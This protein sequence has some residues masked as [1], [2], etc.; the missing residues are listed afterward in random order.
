[1]ATKSGYVYIY[2]SNESPVD[3][4]FDNLQVIHTRGAILEETHYYP[5]GLTMAGISSK[6]LAFGEPEN[7]YKYNGIEHNNDFDLNMYD[8]FYRNLDP[9]IGRFWQVDPETE[10][11][12]EYS[13][14]ASMYNNP[15]SNAD[16]LGDF[17][18]R[19]GAWLYKIFNGGGEIGKNGYGEY[20]VSQASDGGAES[21]VTVTVHYG[22]GRN[23]FSNAVEQ[24]EDQDRSDKIKEDYTQLG[25]WDPN[26]DADQAGKRTL[27]LGMGVTLPNAVI[28]PATITINTAKATDAAKKTVE[29]L[30]NAGKVIDRGDLTAVGRALQKHGSSAGSVFPKVTGNSVSINAQ[31]EAVLKDIITNPSVTTVTRHHARFGNILEYKLPS[32]QGERFSADGNT[33]IGFIE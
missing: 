6:A 11:L 3:V 23:R 4:F 5:F 27:G 20:F 22:K 7:K 1:M 13:P 14:Y 30:L 21:G 17:A 8:A 19:V 32:G 10:M 26:L 24:I 2:V 18:T 33:F 12:E 29:R 9:Q 25:L 16:P 31:G 28:K 15:I